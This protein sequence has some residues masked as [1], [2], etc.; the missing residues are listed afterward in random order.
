MAINFSIEEA[1]ER[2]ANKTGVPAEEFTHCGIT[3]ENGFIQ[4]K[5]YKGLDRAIVYT[6]RSEEE[7]ND[8]EENYPIDY[9]P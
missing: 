5:F 6:V 8:L 1:R 3:K 9:A 4:Y 2:L 7:E